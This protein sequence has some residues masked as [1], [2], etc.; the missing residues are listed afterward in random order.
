MA[1]KR[2]V[3]DTLVSK[4]DFSY[5]KRPTGIDS[6]DIIMSGGYT[7]GDV[8]E[9][10][11]DF[12]TGKSTVFLQI[13]ANLCQQGIK[14][15][16]LDVESAVEDDLLK[17]V[18]LWD[19]YGEDPE[20]ALF[21]KIPTKDNKFP[22]IFNLQFVDDF[23]LEY[24]VEKKIFTHV[25]WDS[26]TQT[27]PFDPGLKEGEQPR[28]NGVRMMSKAAQISNFFNYRKPNFRS[29]GATLWYINQYRTTF[30]WRMNASNTP[31]GG[32]ATKY[33]PDIKL[34][35]KSRKS[36]SL[37]RVEKTVT[38]EK[39]VDYGI[40]SRITTTKNK[41]GRT[42]IEVPFP[43]IYGQGVS[44]VLTLATLLQDADLVGKTR[45]Y[46]KVI[47]FETGEEISVSGGV[48][49][50][51]A[52]VKENLSVIRKFLKENGYYSLTLD[53]IEGNQDEDSQDKDSKVDDK[54]NE[55]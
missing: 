33:Y 29:T 2:S 7:P 45:S 13:A 54:D 31:T 17:N 52:W 32:H 15:A 35:I 43:F 41:K 51:W 39:E 53:E 11:G 22:E 24:V 38:G 34:E 42:G 10:S 37:K 12:G 55:E 8:I 21:Y 19:F 25:M 27:V 49:G 26:L 30:D 48:K 40:F 1:K 28:V 14:V 18:G 20:G 44:N 47:N 3:L 50:Y 36:D 6:I 16:Y 9:L 5:E 4:D 23:I 46:T